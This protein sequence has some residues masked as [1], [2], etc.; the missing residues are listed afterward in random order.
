MQYVLAVSYTSHMVGSSRKHEEG[1][2][3]HQ[4]KIIANAFLWL[5]SKLD[6]SKL[7][8]M[9]KNID[10]LH[11]INWHLIKKLLHGNNWIFIGTSFQWAKNLEMIIPR[12]HETDN[13]SSLELL[14]SIWNSRI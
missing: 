12:R 1:V 4:P 2:K 13:I 14:N 7:K 9:P 5:L 3:K 8:K 10:L 6:P 11:H